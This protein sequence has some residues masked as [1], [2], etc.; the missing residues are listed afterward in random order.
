MED[1]QRQNIPCRGILMLS[2]EQTDWQERAD[3]Q[4]GVATLTQPIKYK[5]LLQTIRSLL[6]DS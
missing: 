6:G 1:A 3:G 5:Q 2:A 4:T